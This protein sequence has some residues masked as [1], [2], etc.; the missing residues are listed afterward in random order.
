MEVKIEVRLFSVVKNMTQKLILESI[1]PFL[2]N[3]YF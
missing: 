3:G 2:F 1:K